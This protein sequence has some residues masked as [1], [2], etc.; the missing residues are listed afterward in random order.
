MHGYA[1]DSGVE[2]ASIEAHV[3]GPRGLKNGR[4]G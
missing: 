4:G 1:V 3:I 2:R